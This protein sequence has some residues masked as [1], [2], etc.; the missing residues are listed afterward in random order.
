MKDFFVVYEAITPKKHLRA[1]FTSPPQTV[2]S[3]R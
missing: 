2:Q 1:A 3:V